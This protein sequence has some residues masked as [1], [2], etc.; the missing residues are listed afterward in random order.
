[1]ILFVGCSILP[2]TT[3]ITEY[4]KA[5]TGEQVLEQE[6]LDGLSISERKQLIAERY[7]EITFTV[8]IYKVEEIEGEVTETRQSFGSGVIV[9]SGGFILTNNHV[10][11]KLSTD[12][13][14]YKC[15]VSQDG[16]DTLYEAFLLWNNAVFD[17]AIII[18]EQF[19]DLN[20]AVMKDRTIFCDDADKIYYT[21]E[22]IT[23]GT[24]TD[25][26]YFSSAT[27]GGIASSKLRV[28]VSDGNLYE[29][30]I[31]HYS[32]INHGCSGGPL[33]DLNGNVIGLNTLGHDGANS[34][35]FAISIYPAIAILDKVVEN[36]TQFGEKTQELVFG[37]MGTDA[38][39][40]KY[41]DSELQFN[42]DGVYVV[43]VNPE[44]IIEGLQSA[45][46]I[47][48][49]T[50]VIGDE[51]VFFEVSDQNTVLYA[52]VHL[53]YANSA[54]VKILRGGTELTLNVDFSN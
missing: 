40:I 25:L 43:S 28:A 29:H 42:S 50:V 7:A 18:C 23:V 33:I 10:V 8:I 34:L 41:S 22:V 9:H 49:L 14:L 3:K 36:Y 54:S 4:K 1:M 16:G 48:G 39:H 5:H 20:A 21:E 38:E 30:L 26:E 37:F 45:D 47:I 44:C 46:V 32:P 15:Y 13:V 35:F 53:L 52:R 2:F 51:T 27:T 12:P 17:M 24:H 31:Q 19:A 6:E 11:D